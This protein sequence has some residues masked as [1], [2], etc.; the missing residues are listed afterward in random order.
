MN[1]AVPLLSFAL[2]SATMAITPIAASASVKA[3]TESDNDELLLPEALFLRTDRKSREKAISLAS[4]RLQR[5]EQKRDLKIACSKNPDCDERHMASSAKS[6][7]SAAYRNAPASLKKHLMSTAK[8]RVGKIHGRRLLQ[9]GRESN[10][11]LADNEFDFEAKAND[12]ASEKEFE[13][14]YEED[15]ETESDIEPLY[16]RTIAAFDREEEEIR[17]YEKN[18]AFTEQSEFEYELSEQEGEN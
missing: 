12:T 3:E 1:L 14:A 6:K 13:I 8:K 11:E 17:A 18:L 5:L 9:N 10:T 16:N 15:V 2:F 7:R 4:K